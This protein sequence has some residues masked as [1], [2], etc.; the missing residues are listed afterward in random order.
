MISA[1]KKKRILG[2]H[3]L[4]YLSRSIDMFISPRMRQGG[5]KEYFRAKL[6]VL[7]SWT[8]IIMASFY[9]MLYYFMCSPATA[10]TLVIGGS[11]GPI[12]LSVLR[13]TDSCL[14]SGNIISFALFSTL[15]ALTCRLGGHGNFTL[16]WYAAVPVV[17]LVTAGRQSAIAWFAIITSLVLAFYSYYTL[18][19]TFANDLDSLK[20]EFV[21]LA[22]TIGLV[23]LIL[24]LVLLYETSMNQ[25]LTEIKIA[26]EKLRVE[27]CFSD[28][29]VDSLPT[30]F[31]VYN[32]DGK[33]LRWNGELERVSGYSSEEIAEMNPLDLVVDQDRELVGQGMQKVFTDGQ[34]FIEANCV[35]R[36]GTVIPYLLT[37][38]R[39]YIDGTLHGLG[40][41][42]DISARIEVEKQLRE[43]AEALK[44]KNVIL[45]ELKEAAEAANCAKSQFLANMSHEIRTPMTSILGYTDFL[46][47]E[48]ETRDLSQEQLQAIDI[49]QQNGH[50]LLQVINNI[51]DL[52]KIEAG[53]IKIEWFSMSPIKI[54]EEVVALMRVRSDAKNLSLRIER[55]G[56]I[57]ERI[58][59][60]PIR[61]RQILINLLSNAIKFTDSGEIHV[62][63]QIERGAEDREALRFDVFD[64][65]IGMTEEQIAKLFRPFTQVDSSM[66]RKHGGTGL[67]LV[68]SKRL[69]TM[70]GGNI[71]VESL[72]GERSMFSLTIATRLSSGNLVSDDQNA[73]LP[74][75]ELMEMKSEI[76]TQCKLDCK[77]LLAEDV[78][79][80]QH[81][82]VAM[83]AK[84]GA[85]VTAVDNG[86]M[87]YQAVMES[88]REDDPYDIV[89]M[90]MQM[91]IMDGYTA[92]QK[93]RDSGYSGAIIAITAHAMNCDKNKCLEVGCDHYITKPID[94]EKLI[95]AIS[96]RLKSDRIEQT[97]EL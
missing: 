50:Y 91:P 78:L 95:K 87:A 45:E 31:Y 9:A 69:A 53:M 58:E 70:L 13:R 38:N 61:L 37:G 10:I 26:E 16:S 52:S 57:P 51:L 8:L 75:P 93:L 29:L 73:E 56:E 54:L 47:E 64:T 85:S 27:K 55:I 17:A 1:F 63:V 36:D 42:I 2:K 68:I 23:I 65:G 12:T 5:A 77:I 48:G 89:L 39:L 79:V 21:N 83:L 34:A 80:N 11:V 25:Y 33:Y 96:R 7:F 62:V 6:I 92:T 49:I 76:D 19:Y 88:L 4:G 81:L 74:E 84:A 3:L 28:T 40:V 82:V 46:K 32:E 18:G 59:S 14:I 86:L 35:T 72:P 97:Q 24:C 90:D 30:I 71:T 94:R 60:D 20:Y 44:D 41:G 43:T 66:T 22:S 67:G 15:T